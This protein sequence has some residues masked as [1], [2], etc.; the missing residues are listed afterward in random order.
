MQAPAVR[1][2]PLPVDYTGPRL[3]EGPLSRVVDVVDWVRGALGAVW[4]ALNYSVVPPGTVIGV[5]PVTPQGSVMW[6]ASRTGIPLVSAVTRESQ[7]LLTTAYQET[8]AASGASIRYGTR[9]AYE[10][11][12]QTVRVA[13][14]EF[15]ATHMVRWIRKPDGSAVAGTFPAAESARGGMMGQWAEQ[16]TKATGQP[17][18]VVTST[19]A[20]Y[21]KAVRP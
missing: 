5:V 18:T 20:E 3:I 10:A 19:I 2:D 13:E 4:D 8:Y 16:M 1:V 7:Q 6:I 17:H 14:G 11:A 21:A 12:K 15:S 9:E